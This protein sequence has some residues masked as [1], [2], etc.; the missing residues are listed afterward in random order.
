MGA[1]GPSIRRP[2]NEARTATM[3][4]SNDGVMQEF[5]RAAIR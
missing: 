3:K 4:L 2:D 1:A 5:G